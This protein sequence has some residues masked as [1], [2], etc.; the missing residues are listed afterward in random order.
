MPRTAFSSEHGRQDQLR[1]ILLSAFLRG[2]LKLCGAGLLWLMLLA[3]VPALAIPPNTPITNTATVDFDV[4]GVGYAVSDSETVITDPNAGNSPPYGLQVDP[5]SIDE[6]DDGGTVGLITVNDPDPTDTHTF[7]VSDPRFTVSGNTLQLLPGNS[8]NFEAEASVTLTV[9]ATDPAGDSFVQTLT[10]SVNDLNEAPT[11]ITLSNQTAVAGQPGAIVGDLAAVDED[12]GDTHTFA[13]DDARFEVVNGQLKLVDTESLALGETVTLLVTATDSGGLSYSESFTLTATPPGGGSGVNSSVSVYQFAPGVPGAQ[14]FDVGIAQCDSGSGF[15]DLPAPQSVF[16]DS[17]AVPGDLE[18]AATNILKSG[19]SLFVQV[20]DPDANMDPAVRER[21]LVTIATLA[22]DTEVISIL[23]TDVD[24]G[25]FVGFIQ[26]VNGPALPGNCS[27]E[28]DGPERLTVSYTDA[29]DA[30]DVATLNVLVDPFGLVFD[31]ATGNPINGALVTIIDTAT[32]SPATVFDDDGVS[33]YPSS[34]DSGDAAFGFTPGQYRFPFVASGDYELRVTPP[35]R[36]A[37]PSAAPDTDLQMLAGAPYALSPGSRGMPF[38]VPVGPAVRVDIPLDLLPVTPTPSVLDLFSVQVG[39]A[40][41]ESVYVAPAQCSDGSTYLASGDP[42]TLAAGGLSVPGSYELTAGS[43]FV[44]GDAVFIRVVD[45]DQD[46]DPFAP[47]T[48]DVTISVPLGDSEQVRLTETNDSTGVFTGYVQTSASGSFSAFNCQ[49]EADPNSAFD[50]SYVDPDD[51]SDASAVQALLDPGFTMFSSAD[52]SLVS[53]ATVT[54]VDAATGLPAVGSVFSVDGVTP[55][56]ETVVVGGSVTDGAGQ[57]FDFAPGTFLFPVVAPGNYRLEVVNPPS[58]TFASVIDDATLNML[59][60]G[61]YTLSPGSR[62]GDFTVVAGAP[63]AFDVPVDPISAEIFVSK[64]ASKDVATVGEF[65]QYQIQVRNGDASGTVTRV[66]LD[67]QLPMGFRYADGSLRIGSNRE[68]PRIGENG[69]RMQVDLP[70]LGPG[71]EVEVRYVAEI[72]SGARVGQARNQATVTGVG[73]GSANV[74]FADVTVREDLLRSK[75]ILVGQVHAN[76]CDEPATGMQ[77]VRVWLEDGTFVVTDKDGKF[78]IEGIEPGTH[79]VQLDLASVPSSHE[80]ILCDDNTRFAGS[81]HSQFIDVQAGTLWRADFHLARKPNQE[82]EVVTRLD[83][84]ALDGIVHYVY[85]VKGGA[86]PLENVRATLMLDDQLAFIGGSAR[87]NGQKVADPGGIEMSAPTFKLPDTQEAFEHRIEFDAFV[88]NPKGLIESKAVVQF[89]SDAGRHRS[90]VNVNELSLNWPSSLVIVAESVSSNR[91][92]LEN[93][94]QSNARRLPARRVEGVVQPKT[95]GVAIQG[96]VHEPSRGSNRTRS[97]VAKTEVSIVAPDVDNRPYQLPKIDRGEAPPFDLAWLTGHQEA[98]GIVWPPERYNPS[99]PAVEVAV[100]HGQTEKPVLMVDGQLVNPITY[101]GTITHH[102]ASLSMTRWDNVSISETDSVI[103]AHILDAD[104]KTLAR[105]ERPVHFSGAPARAELVPTESYLTA[106]GLYPPLLAVR[107]YDRSGYPLRAGTTGEF[108]VSAPYLPLDKAKHLESVDNEVNNIRYQVLRDGIAYIQLEPTTVTGEVE[109]S[110]EFDQVRSDVVRARLNP[111]TRDWIMVGLVEGSYAHNSL[112]GNMT[113]LGALNLE[114]ESLSDGRVAFY[115]KGMV[116]GDWLL[117]AAYDTDKRFERRLREQIDP[118]QFYTLYGDGTEQ[119]Y[120]AES[121]RK[122]YLK[123]E[124]E[125][126]VGLF[127]DFDTDFERSELARYD[128]RMNGVRTGYF[129]ER[130]EIN[131]FA[132]ETDQAFIRDELRGDGTSGVYRLSSRNIVINSEAIRLVTRDRF[133]TDV[134]IEEVALTRYLDY[135][136]DY[137]RGT[138]IFKQPIFSQDAGFNPIFIEAE[139]EVAD[140]GADEEIV[141]GTRMAYRLDENESEIA[142]T[143]VNDGTEGQG[144][145]LMAADLTWQFNPEQKLT[146]E[147]AQTDTDALGAADAYLVELEHAGEKIAGRL[148]YREQEQAFGLG[149]QSTLEA[150]TRKFGVEGEYRVN[151]QVLLRTQ[152]FQQSL[153]SQDA[154]RF[155]ANVEGE[156]RRGDT[157]FRGGLQT[158][159]EETAS[160]ESRDGSQ[161]LMGVTQTLLRNKLMLRGDAEIDV[162]SSGENTD[163]PSRGI[164]GAEYEVMNGVHLIG[165]QELT[166]GDARDTQDTRFGVRAR[167]WTGADVTSLIGRDQGEN[168]ERLFA[169]T[170]LLQQ[171]RINE[172]WMADFGFDR[173]QTLSDSRSTDTPDELLFNPIV[174]PASGSFD[175]DFTAFFTGFSYRHDHWDVSSRVEWHE[176]DDADKLNFLVGANRQLADGKVVALSLASLSEDLTSGAR[177][178]QTDLRVGFAYRPTGSAWS[179]LNRTDLI[180][181]TRDNN[182][183][184]TR[185]NKLVNNFNA[186]FKPHGSVHQVSLQLGLKYVV[187]TIDDREYD[188][189]TMLSGIEYRY[190]LHPRWDL[191]VH[192]SALTSFGADT[193]QYSYGVSV[194]HNLFEN[195]WIS[196][197]YNADGF[198][199]DDFVAAEYTAKG[200]YLKIRMKFDQALANRFLEFA[201]WSNRRPQGFANSH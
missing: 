134:I 119:L 185:T 139:Y 64:Q 7:V 103:E 79:V 83:A 168:G 149:Y 26:T 100:V 174:P 184:D 116:K 57:I 80:P 14:T 164:L 173:V 191:G 1:L 157:K 101:E 144:G 175:D 97:N 181:E 18:L 31:S 135:T 125:R 188:S 63:F 132:S 70:D 66:T 154:D 196:L 65:V 8:L 158:V 86:V 46:L 54:I 167:P 178:D 81:A 127:G 25:V 77:D 137:G 194:G 47:D 171:W 55:F 180:L 115:A 124:K 48:L 183:F 120:D 118:N 162:G 95:S 35:N 24:S 11:D 123:V 37:F 153:L 155:L 133:S 195:A 60:T 32:G 67:D 15:A 111:G 172:R 147:A 112:S 71:E 4:A 170:G 146:V 34:V 10:I 130:V 159:S 36:F 82:S 43:R 199:D 41:S 58:H 68:V 44:R 160:G 42:V 99:M 56:P 49:L 141:A 193:M 20:V 186:N 169:T 78:H 161:V 61:P 165:E 104:G 128:R 163:Y 5:P 189:T 140:E 89:V 33:P 176:G 40:A 113:S 148:Y 17:I 85:R 122:L 93:A 109:L 30:L 108:R 131:A 84:E 114:D 192:T 198:V 187:D 190:D 136:I 150:D 94:R 75:A 179:I 6:N 201:G 166:W 197:G 76:G 107:L 145:D 87:V 50:V 126:F 91:A 12:D 121:Q 90:E 38:N 182:S 110:F 9:T 16:G 106:D 129:G 27:I 13:V 74:A 177:N 51:A 45:P 142:L 200:P 88:K 152:T 23:E 53:D 3:P 69:R 117:T 19:D 22:L 98:R 39:P 2:C 138:V 62:G 73:V 52:G 92:A 151:E 72:T 143:Y 21:L 156:W 105:Y 102:E 28:V 96:E 29:S 59:P